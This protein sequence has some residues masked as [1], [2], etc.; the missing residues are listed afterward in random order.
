MKLRPFSDTQRPR[1]VAAFLLLALR[2]RHGDTL[3]AD[4]PSALASNG[5]RVRRM[6]KAC[7]KLPLR[8]VIPA[9]GMTVSDGVVSTDHTAKVSDVDDHHARSRSDRG[10]RAAVTGPGPW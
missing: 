3:P 4:V 9:R 5:T 2:Y 8:S 10:R 1:Q 7:R 6:R